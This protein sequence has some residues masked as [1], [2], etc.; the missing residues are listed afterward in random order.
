MIA[1][2][3]SMPTETKNRTANA[4]RK[5]SASCVALWLSGDSLMIMPA[6]KA[7]SAKDTPNRADAP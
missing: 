5:G 6:K 4:S 2:S 3:N 1:G 7:P